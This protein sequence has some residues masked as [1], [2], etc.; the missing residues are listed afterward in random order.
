MKLKL[1]MF[2][3]GVMYRVYGLRLGLNFV[4]GLA[5]DNNFYVWLT[6]EKMHAFA[7]FNDFILRLYGCSDTN[8]T[9]TVNCTNPRTET[10]TG[11]I[12]IHTNHSFQKM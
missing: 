5:T 6:V 10:L 4:A 9:A 12:E 8:Y 3:K 7:V 2:M 1:K 11:I